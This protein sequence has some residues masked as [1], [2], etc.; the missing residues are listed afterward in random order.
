MIV[1][2]ATICFYVLMTIGFYLIQSKGSGVKDAVVDEIINSGFEN[3]TEQ[4]E[5]FSGKLPTD[6]IFSEGCVIDESRYY[7]GNSSL[8]LPASSTSEIV[9][10]NYSFATATHKVYKFGLKFYSESVDGVKITLYIG[11]QNDY[12]H[13]EVV[14]S[15]VNEWEDASFIIKFEQP[16]SAGIR[17]V[18]T[19]G[20][21]VSYIDNVYIEEV[22]PL[23]T[24]S[25][26]SIRLSISEPGLRFNGKVDKDFYDFCKKNYIN[27]QVGIIMIPAERLQNGEDFTFANFAGKNAGLIMYE[28][29]K[30][31]NTQTAEKDGYYGFGCANIHILPQDVDTV[32]SAR[33]YLKY[34]ND[35]VETVIYGNFDLEKNSRSIHEI[36]KKLLDNVDDYDETE[37]KIIKH[38]A[39]AVT[40]VAQEQDFVVQNDSSL[41]HTSS[42]KSGIIKITADK[43]AVIKVEQNGVEIPLDD[44]F[45]YNVNDGIIK[46]TVTGSKKVEVKHYLPFNLK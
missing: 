16:I 29:T 45:V 39:T 37:K 12:R 7:E 27:V 36:A 15:K 22:S 40:K 1:V 24:F 8:R 14:P 2:L 42:V 18:I 26:A 21:S 34:A 10:E 13:H 11:V 9:P 38:Y 19:T 35:G 33:S 17:I 5:S 44:K 30:W 28:A 31:N 3:S 32:Y 6:W 23:T 4:D 46:I 43:D 25:G 20:K 41:V